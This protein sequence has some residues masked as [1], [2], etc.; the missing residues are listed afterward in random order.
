MKNK[1][2]FASCDWKNAADLID[3]LIEKLPQ[4]GVH[5]EN[6]ETGGD[7]FVMAISST[8]LNEDKVANLEETY[9]KQL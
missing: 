8:K 2:E 3:Q 1:L 9:Y 4:F 6:V 5:A 7:S